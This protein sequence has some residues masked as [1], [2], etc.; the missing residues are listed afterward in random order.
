MEALPGNAR[1]REFI[2]FGRW[3]PETALLITNGGYGSINYALDCGVP[4]IVAGTGEDKLEAA[5]RVVAAGC[6]ISL[7]TSTPT[8]EQIRRRRCAFCNSRSIGNARRWCV[9]IMPATTR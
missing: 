5:A 3:L 1:V 6:G 9:R 4:L 2:S 7:H 8:A